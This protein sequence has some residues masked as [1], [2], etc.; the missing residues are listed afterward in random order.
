MNIQRYDTES[1]TGYANATKGFLDKSWSGEG[2][3]DKYHKISQKQGLNNSVSD[4]FVEDGSF[5]RVKNVQI[6]Y[7]F[8]DSFS[9]RL[10]AS[11]LRVYVGAQNLF[12]LTGYSGLDPEIG[13]ADPKLNGI[14]QGYYPQARTFML[15]INAK[16]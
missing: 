3:T 7:N 13:S 5:L 10:K 9:K 16:F 15:G 6:G 11:Q 4:Y 14:D 8:A 12:T 2:S 1:G